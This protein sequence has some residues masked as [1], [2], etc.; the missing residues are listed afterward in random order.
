ME[1]MRGTG[2]ACVQP[3]EVDL[4]LDFRF[5]TA[6]MKIALV[7]GVR[8]DANC[9][10]WTVVARDGTDTSA[11]EAARLHPFTKAGRDAAVAGAKCLAERLNRG[12]GWK[13]FVWRVLV[14]GPWECPLA[15]TPVWVV[16]RLGRPVPVAYY[17]D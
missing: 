1:M 9:R 17:F 12:V 15:V 6:R 11:L 10:Q 14:E 4:G 7:G 5:D 3:P 2:T 16:E 8:P 13:D